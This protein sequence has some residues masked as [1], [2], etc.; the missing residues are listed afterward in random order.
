MPALF[1]LVSALLYL[2]L[3]QVH[4]VSSHVVTQSIL[5]LD[6]YRWLFAQHLD[7]RLETV[8]VKWFV[9]QWTS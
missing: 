3:V 4:H 6:T 8:A 9:A 5:V 7:E 2:G 1:C